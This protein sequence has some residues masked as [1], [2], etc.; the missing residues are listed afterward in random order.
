M[1]GSM[2]SKPKPSDE[3][4]AFQSTLRRVLQCSKEE[5][6]AR[7][8]EYQKSREGLPKRGPKPKTSASGRASRA[9]G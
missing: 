4:T 8:L 2:K 5:L 1:I 9:Q 3:Y 7:E 6:K